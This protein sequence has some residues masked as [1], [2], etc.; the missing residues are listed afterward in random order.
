MIMRLT[1]SEQYISSC[2]SSSTWTIWKFGISEDLTSLGKPFL[3]LGGRIGGDIL[4]VQGTATV[5]PC[6]RFVSESFGRTA[7]DGSEKTAA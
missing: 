2:L 7:P 4:L 1:N 5:Y 3:C 6:N